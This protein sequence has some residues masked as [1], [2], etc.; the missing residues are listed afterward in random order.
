[1]SKDVIQQPIKVKSILKVQTTNAYQLEK[2][3]GS[4]MGA[5]GEMH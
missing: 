2:E 1:M 4:A 5:R 3:K